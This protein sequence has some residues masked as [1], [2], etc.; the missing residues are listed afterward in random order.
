MNARIGKRTVPRVMALVF[1]YQFYFL[2]SI[3]FLLTVHDITYS[4][5]IKLDAITHKYLKKWAGIPRCGTNLIFHMKDGLQIKSIKSLYEEAHALNHAAIRIK[6]DETVNL[7][8]DNRLA[9]E[10]QF[11]RKKSIAVKSQNAY[12]KALSLNCVGGELPTFPDDTWDREKA[13]LIEEIK[14][15]IKAGLRVESE[16]DY[17]KHLHTLI[18]QGEFLKISQLEQQDPIW[19]SFIHNLKKGTM[20]FLLNSMIDTLPTKSNLKLWNKTTS[21]KCGLCQNKETTLHVLNGCRTALM[22]GRFTWRHDNILR[23]I[24]NNI[25]KEKYTV[26]SDIPDYKT[27]NGGSMPS[28]LTITADRP[29]LVILDKSK[30]KALIG[31]LTV[32]FESNVAERHTYKTNRYAY[33]LKDITSYEPSLCAFEIGARGFMTTENMKR[34]KEIHKFCNKTLTFKKFSENISAI[35]ITSSYYIFNCRKEPSW[36][37]PEPL[38]PPLN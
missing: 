15:T 17:S 22:Q 10:A 8:L 30:K 3:R 27:E 2:P 7:A 34:L 5:L 37:T 23:Y 16:S 28:F 33:L 20:K 4:D 11:V 31:E 38:C 13:K 36:G 19:K 25:D 26:F 32:P 29:D 6:G 18:K 35:S 24:C 21:D 1:I 14:T 12:D 9:R